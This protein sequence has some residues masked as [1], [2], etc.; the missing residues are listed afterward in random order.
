M[1]D[2][3]ENLNEARQS[4]NVGKVCFPVMHEGKQYN[5][6]GYLAGEMLL[7]TDTGYLWTDNATWTGCLLGSDDKSDYLTDQS[8]TS[9]PS[10]VIPE[11]KRKRFAL[12]QSSSVFD[13]IFGYI[14][15]KHFERPTQQGAS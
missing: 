12:P 11:Y 10:L 8:L 15:P 5:A 13:T 14:K 9:R 1:S 7:E 4:R 2:F 6:R 3:F